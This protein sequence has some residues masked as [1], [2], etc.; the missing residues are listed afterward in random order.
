M[1]KGLIKNILIVLLLT[2]A[3]FCVFKYIWALKEKY[4][5][6]VTLNEVKTQLAALEKERQ[7]LLQSLEKEKESQQ[8]LSEENL[9][10]KENLKASK[11][12]LSSLFRDVTEAQKAIEELH[13]R[14]SLLQA[15][16]TALIETEKKLSQENENLKAKLSSVVEIK[17]AFRELKKQA[18]KVA[19][20]IRQKARSTDRIITGN[21]G[22]LI[23]DGKYTYPAKVRIEVIPVTSKN[24]GV[25]EATKSETSN[26]APPK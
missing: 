4:D 18:S 1:N 6:L 13:S 15:E 7:N 14:F 8:K 17:K 12:R 24:Q 3:I 26:E 5:L 16:N 23:K 20:A 19:M 25:Q 11:R 2:I 10:L 21:R 9:G 22:F